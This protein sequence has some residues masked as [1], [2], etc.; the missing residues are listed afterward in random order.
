MGEE[1]ALAQQRVWDK[2]Q[3]EART[4]SLDEKP[5]EGDWSGNLTFPVIAALGQTGA[6]HWE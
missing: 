6:A 5:R 4:M 1:L 3:G 2:E